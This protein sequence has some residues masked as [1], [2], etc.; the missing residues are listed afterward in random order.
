MKP[1]LTNRRRFSATAVAAVLWFG[2]LAA[3]PWVAPFP[4][5]P[6][7][8]P[9]PVGAELHSVNSG[10]VDLTTSLRP[11]LA[12]PPNASL[13][14]G[15][16]TFTLNESG[17]FQ[18][19]VFIETGFAG[20][21]GVFRS[22]SADTLGTALFSLEPGGTVGPD[23]NGNPGGRQYTVDRFLS[24]DESSALRAGNLWA[25]YMNADFPGGA[26][27]GQILTVPE[28][29]TWA[30]LALGLGLLVCGRAARKAD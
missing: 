27:R 1:L 16:G 4:E 8:E 20:T 30:L 11:A 14:N 24:N 22:E 15:F 12:L 13:Y 5:L 26:S 29:A 6:C 19:A 2:S 3:T 28:P 9:L 10:Q 18:G 25:V 21:L 23:G 7:C 17:H